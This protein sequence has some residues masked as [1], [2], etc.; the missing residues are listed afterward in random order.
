MRKKLILLLVIGLIFPSLVRAN[1]GHYKKKG[2]VG[3]GG[4]VVFWDANNAS[5]V[6]FE[7]HADQ[8]DR[9]YCEWYNLQK[10][11]MPHPV[12]SATEPLKARAVA[13]AKNITSR[14]C[15]TGLF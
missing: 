10:D 12:D 5:L 3:I 8:T 9:A 4:W 7:K 13:A 11:C 2:P 6:S 14:K 1:N 15:F